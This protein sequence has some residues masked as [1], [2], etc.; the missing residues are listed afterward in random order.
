MTEDEMNRFIASL[1]LAAPEPEFNARNLP[2]P[3]P[4]GTIQPDTGA[5]VGGG[6][7][8]DV[9]GGYRNFGITPGFRAGPV[10]GSAMV[11]AGR[12]MPTP[13]VGY[14]VNAE[15]PG[16]FNAGYR[17]SH[18]METPSRYDQHMVSLARQILGN[19]VSGSMTQQ[20]GR[21]GFGVGVS[22]PLGGGGNA[23][24]NAQRDPRGGHTVMGGMD[25]RFARG[26]VPRNHPMPPPRPEYL[27]E[28]PMPPP[29]PDYLDDHPM[30]P[31]RP[32]YLDEHPMPPPR[33]AYLDESP[34]PPPRPEGLG[35]P[36]D[37]FAP[38][39][40]F[41]SPAA[42]YDFG[43]PAQATPEMAFDPMFTDSEPV[44]FSMDHPM[45]PPRP[46]DLY[47]HPMPPPRPANLGRYPT[48]TGGKFT[49]RA[50]PLPPE[51]PPAAPQYTTDQLLQLLP[52]PTRLPAEAA[53]GRAV[54]QAKAIEAPTAPEP[55]P[56]S[57][58]D[59]SKQSRYRGPI[60]LRPPEGLI[61]HH[62]GGH[63]TP[64]GVISTLNQRTGGPLGVHYVIDREG[65]IYQTLKSG[66]AGAHMLPSEVNDLS[67][68]NTVGVEVIA[69]HDKDVTPQ[70]IEAAYR[71]RDMLRKSNPN[72]QIYGHGELNTH[73]RASEGTT[74]ANALRTDQRPTLTPSVP[75]APTPANRSLKAYMA[76]E[77]GGGVD[78][79]AARAIQLARGGY[80]TTGGVDGQ[81][82]AP[83]EPVEPVEPERAEKFTDRVKPLAS[84][85]G[86][87]QGAPPPYGSLRP[88]APPVEPPL[89]PLP[90][91]KSMA[92]PFGDLSMEPIKELPLHPFGTM[93][94]I[95]MPT[96]EPFAPRSFAPTTQMPTTEPPQSPPPRIEMPAVEPFTPP[97]AAPPIQMPPIEPFTFKPYTPPVEA[98]PPAIEMPPIEP[99]TFKPFIPEP[100]ARPVQAAPTEAPP[101][102]PLAPELFAPE[103]LAPAQTF[104]LP[105]GAP[106]ADPSTFKPVN[107]EGIADR[108][109]NALSARRDTAASPPPV[110]DAAPP[111]AAPAPTARD[112][113]KLLPPT[114]P[115]SPAPAPTPEPTPAAPPARAAAAPR[116]RPPLPKFTPK[117]RDLIIRTIAAESS[118]RTP[119]ETQAIAHV[120]LNRIT[121]K[122]RRYGKTPERVILKKYAF[123]PWLKPRGQNYPMK[124]KPGSQRWQSAEAAL[125]EAMTGEDF[126]NG[127]T[128]FWA[129]K[130]Q[131][132]LG[133][134]P[135]SWSRKTPG[136]DIGATRFHREADGGP[137]VEDE[138][139]GG[140][141][142]IDRA[143]DVVG[144]SRYAGD[145]KKKLSENYVERE[146]HAGG[147]RVVDSALDMIRGWHGSGKQFR[148]FD[149][150]KMGTGAGE[151][152]GRGAYIATDEDLARKYRE[153]GIYGSDTPKVGRVPFQTIYSDME[154]RAADLPSDE[155]RKLYNRMSIMEDA[156]GGD[157][158]K[159]QS[160]I[161]QGAYDPEAIKWF[162][163]FVAPKIWTP[164]GLYEVGI[165][166]KPEQFM[167]WQSPLSEQSPFIQDIM[168]PKAVEIAD[169]A[170]QARASML[171]RG[172]DF[173][174]RA[175]PPERMEAFKQ[176]VD[177][178]SIPGVQLYGGTH[179]DFGSLKPQDW[180][181]EANQQLRDSGI[182]GNVYV[183]NAPSG[184]LTENYV[185][186][187]PVKDIDILKRYAHG[188]LVHREHHDDG[189]EVGDGGGY[190][191]APPLTI[192]RGVNPSVEPG[193]VDAPV[194][195]PQAAPAN[196]GY[197]GPMNASVWDRLPLL[198]NQPPPA[199]V[200]EQA[201]YKTPG[202]RFT[203][204][205]GIESLPKGETYASQGPTGVE[206]ALSVIPKP[207]TY[208][209][210]QGEA[211]RENLDTMG[212]GWNDL[213]GGN[214]AAGA[215]GL[216]GG[217]LGWAYSPITGAER[218]LFRDPVLEGSGDLRKAEAAELVADTAIGG[219]FRG[220][221]NMLRGKKSMEQL[222]AEPWRGMRM[223]SP[224]EAAGS[225]AAGM[226][227]APDEAEGAKLP[228]GEAAAR[229]I[230]TAKGVI[231]PQRQLSPLGLY[232]HGAETAAGLQ[233]FKGTPEQMIA[234]LRRAS[235]KPDELFY[236]GIVDEAATMAE[237]AR[238]ESQYAP[239]I[240]QAEQALKALRPEYTDVK[241]ILNDPAFKEAAKNKQTPEGQA[242]L[243][244]D[245]AMN[246][247]RSEMD[248]AMVLSKD[249]ASRPTITRDELAEQFSQSMPQIEERVIRAQHNYPHSANEE[250]ENA[251]AQAERRRNFDEV[252]DLT[253]A[254]E[255]HAGHG[256]EGSPRFQRYT[257]PG[258]R[259]YR[260]IVLKTPDETG[261]LMKELA[262][263]KSLR[264]QATEDYA[265]AAD[266]SPEAAEALD[267]IKKYVKLH[268]EL[269]DKKF[270][271][272]DQ[273]RSQ[274]YSDDLGYLL[275][276][277]LSDRRGPNGERILH[278]EE[279]Q[280]DRGQRGRTEG[281]RSPEAYAQWKKADDATRTAYQRA[282]SYHRTLT[283]SLTPPINE[284]FVAGRESPM[285][286]QRR[287]EAMEAQRQDALRANPEWAASAE[288]LRQASDARAAVGP[289]PSTDGVPTG[290]YVTSTQGW[291]DLAV[292]RI[293]K[294]AAQGGYD[295]IV[296]TPGAEQAKRYN[297]SQHVD[298]I[299]HWREGNQIGLSA[300]GPNGT[301][302]DQRIVTPEELPGL[303]GQELS[304][305]IL[306][307]EGSARSISG[308]PEETGVSFISG[309]GLDIGGE[310]M[311][312]YYEGIFAKT[313]QS[314][315]KR[316]DRGAKLG[317]KMI[318]GYDQPVGGLT[319]TPEMRESINRG[320]QSF[321]AD[322]GAVRRGRDGDEF[323]SGAP[324]REDPGI[325]DR[326]LSFLSQFNP[327]GSAEAGPLKELARKAAAATKATPPSEVSGL[328]DYSRLQEVPKVQQFDL[329]RYAPPR[330]VPERVTGLV[331]DP[332]LRDKMMQ[333]I[334]S[335]REMGGPN[336]YNTDP[337]R[338]KFLQHLG[339]NA[340]DAAHRKYMDFVAAT[341]PRSKVGENL[342]N[343][344]YYYGREMRGEGMPAVGDKNPQPYGHYAQ[345]LHQMNANRVAGPGW[346]PLVNPKPASFIENLVGNQ[347]PATIDT[348][349]FRL[350]AMLARD[351]RFLETAY[352]AS[353]GSPKLNIERMVNSGEM[354]V[355][356]ALK[357]PAYWESQPKKNE[358]GAMERY[359]QG[360]ARDMGM[361]P[362]QTQASAWVGG[363][364]I[365]GL[366][367]DESKPFLRFF[368]DR[369]MDTARAREMDPKDVLRDFI[370][371]KAPLYAD[372]GSVVDRAL[373][374]L[375]KRG[376]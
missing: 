178:G 10:S 158:R 210:R 56:F 215:L 160:I 9:G 153:M 321:R 259:N 182:V 240:A 308:Y 6:G 124:Q 233:Q 370:T 150:K 221:A 195:Y 288:R 58:Q 51:E 214:Y 78:D 75:T 90:A 49:N 222:A 91:P 156:W 53:I 191:E 62:T 197:V 332:D 86:T 80:A 174:G 309:D 26:G 281:F 70:Q 249:W 152:Y 245:K 299:A 47:S 212:R 73:K 276:L 303:V 5:F 169:V 198:A 148:A 115:V 268:N 323:V 285:A 11:A 369:V 227:F 374:L 376:G 18:A 237:R 74:I 192:Y 1:S 274:H 137:V 37:N 61:F 104:A 139:Y 112:L 7:E 264:A 341:S 102:I 290:P 225:G 141:R 345:R 244:Y 89:R 14:S 205:L 177:P 366:G 324:Q 273:Y 138:D 17:R 187:D 241:Q 151:V 346:D 260:E 94:P 143:L 66:M 375:S 171:Q 39:Y 45:P 120:I 144:G 65:Q 57:A 131:A 185:V 336:W 162:N 125:Q 271:M 54:S 356:D 68:Q 98:A 226:T 41:G 287:I 69:H 242:K 136:K 217:L 325:V 340:G 350:P 188:G 322:G 24:I 333:V 277:R 320:Q 306:N 130:A 48:P 343:A 218:V 344:S 15:L 40:D 99:F 109:R 173:M 311:E 154:K 368:D 3:R 95:E 25:M 142:L 373:M 163:N 71:L 362:A 46:A 348:H 339:A 238:I 265:R 97:S 35:A 134:S 72:I 315:A 228:S 327:I 81:S 183:G 106:P 230:Q 168:R 101:F 43:A 118:H 155:A 219:G 19:N 172:K 2:P 117:Q 140:A 207:G 161:S 31:P 42:V 16:G 338:D 269:I 201:A 21:R 129:P 84:P 302:F 52:D 103:P 133:R 4:Y 193:P 224:A 87:L 334:Q 349:A 342:R 297:L 33:P 361:T 8:T 330:G 360:I 60:M 128:L 283:D 113:V 114:Q 357:T 263:A 204:A 149:P 367:S 294:E 331:D 261:P 32:E 208:F 50:G 180:K 121:D 199:S 359:Y 28:H 123:E 262:E 164:G 328:F 310:K 157:K 108:V 126:T 122:G 282:N 176:T 253:R 147:K 257:L 110:A 22:R 20:D 371:G 235:V 145:P 291:T 220:F 194:Q 127:A 234:S 254:W 170:N 312:K 27:D 236:S 83:V 232:S 23:F 319:V 55:V 165:K 184:A 67:N 200:L 105:M 166:A 202:E 100:E 296:W 280:S 76:R 216:G 213:L 251:I 255:E 289:A 203:S 82:E 304:K 372:G 278:V 116:Q 206:R 159:I 270:N 96:V 258:G 352:E 88:P 196:D 363:G 13:G 211:A 358:Y 135:P 36:I 295:E 85:F 175:Y 59:I 107:A 34:M 284:P 146:G 266:N 119:A 190:P 286:Y 275:H 186:Y 239:Q 30:P 167:H 313:L 353:K 300:S 301:I 29:R 79:Y 365:T 64:Q 335:G 252:D 181:P 250:W 209:Q 337:L 248:S 247:I 272:P 354:T 77:H 246:P 92:S 298:E 317:Q 243:L 189:R 132:A 326:A 318:S 256:G 44:G 231:A 351:P 38:E 355:E 93:F 307:G 293:L 223:P 12:D 292:K 111:A 316:H 267:R 305:K 279:V 179:R 347:R 229:A 364:K 329:P 314:Q 63:G